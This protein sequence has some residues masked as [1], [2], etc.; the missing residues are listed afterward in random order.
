MKY[1]VIY[2][3]NKRNKTTKQIAI[4]YKIEDATLWE[5]Y[6]QQ[7]GYIDSEIVPVL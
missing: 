1:Q 3:R 4:F 7:Q 6:I 5:K 2:Y